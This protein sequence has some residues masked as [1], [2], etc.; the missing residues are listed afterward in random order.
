MVVVVVVVIVVI[1]VL[2]YGRKLRLLRHTRFWKM[3]LY[4]GAFYGPAPCLVAQRDVCK[5]V[6]SWDGVGV[7]GKRA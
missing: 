1:D 5:R 2:G 6:G 3:W 4:V 7:G